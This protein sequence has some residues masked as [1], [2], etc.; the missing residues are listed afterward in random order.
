MLHGQEPPPEA[1]RRLLIVA[2]LLVA[3]IVVV[4]VVLVSPSRGPSIHLEPPYFITDRVF[5]L[6][7]T[8]ATP[9]IAPDSL[10]IAL[11][12]NGTFGTPSALSEYMLVGILGSIYM[13]HWDDV[14]SDSLLTTG[15][16]FDIGVYAGA[17]FSAPVTF[18]VLGND[19]RPLASVVYSPGP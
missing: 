2:I 15:D 10:R 17:P 9:P 1:R 14:N 13:I 7:V 5:A 16:T 8:S 11:A 3:A 19:G 4:A 12:V 6:N 18:Q